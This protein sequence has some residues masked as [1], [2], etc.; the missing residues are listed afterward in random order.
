MGLSKIY[1]PLWPFWFGP[2]FII[3]KAYRSKNDTFSNVLKS[4]GY[5]C[6]CLIDMSRIKDMFSLSGDTSHL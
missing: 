1:S 2:W 5:A 4:M 6:H 3:H